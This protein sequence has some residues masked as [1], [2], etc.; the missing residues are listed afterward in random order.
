MMNQKEAVY[1]AVV[2]VTGFTGEGTCS[3]TKEQRAQISAILF[4]GFRGG[5]IELG[6]EF[7]DAELKG[8]VSGLLS[9]W[10]RK[11][12]RLNGNVSYVAK[13]PGSKAGSTDPQIKALR[14]LMSTLT[15]VSDKVEIQAAIDARLAEIKPAAVVHLDIES[16][17]EH[18]KAKF[19]K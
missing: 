13:N 2:N 14:A 5:K 19:V 15:S 16:L 18:I 4:E 6:K 11:D 1:S 8:Y 9:N 3:P 7:D 10:L 17:P 12:K